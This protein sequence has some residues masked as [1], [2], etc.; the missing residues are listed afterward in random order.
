MYL[1]LQYVYILSKK[2]Y[3]EYSYRIS[4]YIYIYIYI[5]I[6]TYI[7]ITTHTF[8]NNFYLLLF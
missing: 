7:V 3:D 4:M 6:Y 2:N 5:Y 1:M 8:F